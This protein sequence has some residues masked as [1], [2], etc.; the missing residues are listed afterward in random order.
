MTADD[1]D[2]HFVVFSVE[3]QRHAIPLG[4]VVR[5]IHAVEITPL[6]GAPAVV[7]GVVNVHGSAVPAVNMRKRLGL[8]LRPTELGDHFLLVE[9]ASHPLLLITDTV[10]H[11]VLLSRHL[12]KAADPSRGD[13]L[14]AVVRVEE[15]VILVD[16]VD[17]LL[18]P[19]EILQLEGAL[20]CA[21][22]ATP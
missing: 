21:P 4:R 16:D 5:V 18:K 10:R 11:V 3:G 15:G 22:G 7:D 13:F 1:Q 8:P 19:E 17:R 9:T 2:L 14:A 20:Q 6:T 12:V